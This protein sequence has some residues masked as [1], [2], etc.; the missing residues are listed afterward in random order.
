MDK[1]AKTKKELL[2]ERYGSL[3][4]EYSTWRPRHEEIID[5][6]QPDRG[7]FVGRDQPNKGT[8]RDQFILDAT[9]SDADRKL[10]AAIS[11]GVVS[12]A[13]EWLRMQSTLGATVAPDYLYDVQTKF[14]SV[15]AK[16]NLYKGLDAIIGDDTG[17]GTGVLWLEEDA[18]THVRGIHFPV[19]SYRLS[20]DARGRAD[21]LFRR[22][23]MKVGNL[24]REF[25]GPGG[26]PMEPDQEE[27][28]FSNVSK[29]VKDAWE[30]QHFDEYVL[31]QHSV[32][33]RQLRQYGKLDAKNKPWS[34]CWLEVNAEDQ[35]KLLRESGFAKQPFVVARWDYVGQN[36][37]GTD[38]PSMMAIGDIKQLQSFTM[39]SAKMV[40]KIVDP[41]MN[42]PPSMMN[43]SIVPGAS[44]PLP[45][46]STAKFEPSMLVPPQALEATYQEKQD[47]RARIRQAYLNNVLFYL[48]GEV[49]ARDVQKTAEEIRARK[50]EGLLQLS[51]A[52]KI[53]S[54][55][56]L[57]PLVEFVL[58]VMQRHGLIDP[59]PSE[60]HEVD[61][62]GEVHAT[63]AVEYINNLAAAQKLL[64]ISAVERLINSAIGMFSGTQDPSIL[65]NVDFDQVIHILADTLGV[66]PSLVRAADVVKALRD[67]RQQAQQAKAQGEAMVQ[68]AGAVKDISQVDP[69]QLDALAQRFGP[70]AQTQ[71]RF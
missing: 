4:N 15:M 16:S 69:A 28:D 38:S 59:P 39:A 10:R 2:L 57:D 37:Y 12:P 58:D 50:D 32:E 46:N 65:D 6:V 71:V 8:R 36:A 53:F 48:T 70:Y 43:A 60:L 11:T 3:D 1:P 13:R 31:V 49:G 56:V 54:D 29:R 34:S 42:K 20:T 45:A 7:A 47:L 68:G 67:A 26:A 22:F 21:T 62:T 41:P 66:K 17:P 52:Y 25:C 51:G 14:Y 23:D 44:N 64:G 24:V 40:A 33:P 55:E 27:P 30:Q 63:V 61:H 18:K 19:G 35:T 5:N 9:A